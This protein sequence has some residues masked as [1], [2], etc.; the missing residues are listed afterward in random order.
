MLAKGALAELALLLVATSLILLLVVRPP[1]PLGPGIDSR[2]RARC[3]Q[4]RAQSLVDDEQI[5]HA[6]SVIKR[7]REFLRRGEPHVSTLVK[8]VLAEAAALM[9]PMVRS[10]KVLLQL[11]VPAGLPPVH[12]DRVQIGQVVTN[13]IKNSIDAIPEEAEGCIDVKVQV[14]DAGKWVGIAVKDSGPGISVAQAD[15]LF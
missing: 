3:R 15:S 9:E 8:V 5:D 4:G 13:L 14:T 12:G 7:M 2:A 1:G 11:D 6:G 10:R